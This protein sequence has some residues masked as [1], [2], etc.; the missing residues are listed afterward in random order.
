MAAERG[1]ESTANL[2]VAWTRARPEVPAH[3]GRAVTSPPLGVG[4]HT[5]TPSSLSVAAVEQ[6][7]KP[8]ASWRSGAAVSV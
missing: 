1:R 2:R 4:Q 5:L 6:R 8:R 3:P 7:K